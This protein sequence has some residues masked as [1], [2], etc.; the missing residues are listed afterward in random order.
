MQMKSVYRWSLGIVGMLTWVIALAEMD[1]QQAQQ[2][3]AETEQATATAS[4]P[5]LLDRKM[6]LIK[7]LYSSIP[8]EK[9][10]PAILQQLDEAERLEQSGELFEAEKLLNQTLQDVGKSSRRSGSSRRSNDRLKLR[11]EEKL[12]HYDSLWTAMQEILQE[13]QQTYGSVGNLES[14]HKR[15]ERSKTY[16]KEGNYQQANNQIDHAYRMLSQSLSKLRDK[17]TLQHRLVFDSPKDEYEYEQR[18]Y[19]THQLLLEMTLAEKADP[20]KLTMAV[21]RMARAAE[22]QNLK[23]QEEAGREDYASAVKTQERA[24]DFL[25]NALRQAGLYLPQ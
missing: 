12:T 7:R 15:L 6:E 1:G 4:A 9:R 23:A 24:T 17:E 3:S 22:E 20:T 11:Y 21:D 19:Q 18:R 25:I 14:L 10:D 16:A 2:T 5:H 13:K 8:E